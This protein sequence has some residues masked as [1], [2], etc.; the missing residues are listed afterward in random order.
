MS[1]FGGKA[2][3]SC[4]V[5]RFFMLYASKNFGSPVTQTRYNGRP[6]RL[7]DIIATG[8]CAGVGGARDVYL[9]ADDAVRMSIEGLGTLENSVV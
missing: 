2:N 5:G 6:I 3:I 7:G 8:T 4:V 9:K 1:A